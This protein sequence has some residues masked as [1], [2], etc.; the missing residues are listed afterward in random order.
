MGA[1]L[2]VTVSHL[3]EVEGECTSGVGLRRRHGGTEKPCSL[4]FRELM[5]RDQRDAL[6]VHEFLDSR[7]SQDGKFFITRIPQPR[8]NRV[9]FRVVVTGMAYE[10]PR[11]FR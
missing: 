8:C 9:Q 7:R 5:V 11:A 6:A 1:T 4:G 3:A 10:F 2:E